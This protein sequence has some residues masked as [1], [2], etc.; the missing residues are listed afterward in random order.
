MDSRHLAQEDFDRAYRRGFWKKISSW[1]SGDHNE[2]L[3]FDVVKDRIP[4]RGQH[5]LGLKQVPIEQI[6]GSLGRYRDFDRAFLPRQARTKGRW[7]SIDS[8][9]YEEINLPPV[10]LFKMGEVYFVRDGN[11]RVSVARDQGQEFIDAEVIEIEIPVPL[12]AD[13]HIDDLDLKA[14]YANFLEETNLDDIRPGAVIELT[15]S[16]EYERI[17]EHINVHR[18][19]LGEGRQAKVPYKEAVASW[20]DKVYSPLVK[21]ISEQ[22][23]LDNFPDHTAADLYLWIIEYEWFLR[24]AYR[25][26]F[27]FQ[28]VSRQFRERFKDSPSRKLVNILKKSLWVD[29]LILEQERQ[30]FEDRTLLTDLRPESQVILTTPGLYDKLLR[31]IDIHRWYL[32]EKI[33]EEVPF[34]DAVISWYDIVYMPFV[35][36]IREKNILREFPGRTETDLYVWILEHQSY[37]ERAYEMDIPVEV[38][39]DHFSEEKGEGSSKK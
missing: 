33:D 19:F 11:H 20:Y 6:V 5:Y 7:V 34:E 9:H 28:V 15:L 12:T 1:I 14:E 21:L 32:S 18:W 37:L 8:A 38:A 4:L 17:L 35:E 16:G 22:R 29:N 26:E 3:P 27:S 30:D 24:E 23:L 31:H 2:L 13:V 25:N 10:E 39:M 36:L